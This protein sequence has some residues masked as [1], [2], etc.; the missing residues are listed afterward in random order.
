MGHGLCAGHRLTVGSVQGRE[1]S[2]R[3]DPRPITSRQ[4]PI[5][6]ALPGAPLRPTCQR[7]M[8]AEA[9]DYRQNTLEERKILKRVLKCTYC[10][11]Q[12][13]VLAIAFITTSFV[14][15]I[16]IMLFNRATEWH[17]GTG[18]IVSQKEEKQT[19]KKTRGKF[20]SSYLRTYTR[21]VRLKKDGGRMTMAIGLHNHLDRIDV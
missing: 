10:C 8:Y 16:Q 13:P 14:L 11:E 19:W 1:R 5:T 18:V 7:R 15:N 6:S 17:Y 12:L 3:V 20:N 21:L 9:A 2:A 4:P